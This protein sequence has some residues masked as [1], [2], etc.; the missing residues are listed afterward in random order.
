M[1][2]FCFPHI[3]TFS[4]SKKPDDLI[5]SDLK[6]KYLNRSV[7][8]GKNILMTGPTGCG[9]TQSIIAL[10]KATGRDDKLFK[11][12]F[13][14]SQDARSML[15]GNTHLKKAGDG[16]VTFFDESRFIKAI[17]TPNAIILLDEISRASVDAWNILFP[18]LDEIQRYVSLDEKDGSDII[19]VADGVAILAT[20]N[21][22]T[23]YT[24][25]RKMDKA[26]IDRFQVKIEMVPL[27]LEEE[28]Q[29]IATRYPDKMEIYQEKI[30]TIL[31]IVSEIRNLHVQGKLSKSASTR[32]VL[33]MVELIFD[34][35]SL[36]EIVECTI[37]P[38]Y[39]NS[40]GITSERTIVKQLVQKYQFA[41]NAP[42]FA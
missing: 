21:I 1:P 9:K 31:S 10:A 4:I 25:T 14:A 35:F 28:L 29:L 19:K 2:D 5:I 30:T 3:M 26:F 32:L 34:E 23:D 36:E 22:G 24:A 38:E 33:E 13:G 41:T 7:V 12:N 42:L 37:Y 8:R 17:Q 39:D 18:I 11:F 16:T 6:W 20:A 40:S 15:I 27:T